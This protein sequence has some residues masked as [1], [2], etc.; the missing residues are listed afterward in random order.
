VVYSAALNL[1]SVFMMNVPRSNKLE[2]YSQLT[3]D[4]LD[5]LDRLPIGF[6]IKF[7]DIGKK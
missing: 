1:R 3:D 5:Q 4:D 2:H 7:R 6:L